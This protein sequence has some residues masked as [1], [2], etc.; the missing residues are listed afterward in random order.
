[1]S[2]KLWQLKDGRYEECRTCADDTAAEW[3]KRFQKDEPG[4]VFVL[5]NKRPPDAASKKKE[6]RVPSAASLAKRHNDAVARAKRSLARE[7]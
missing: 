3:L 5:S 1:M 2:I 7:R 6:K 4:G